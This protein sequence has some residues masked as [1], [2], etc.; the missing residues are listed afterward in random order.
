M[1]H[2]YI[3]FEFIYSKHELLFAEVLGYLFEVQVFSRALDT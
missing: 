1:H 3:C 2:N